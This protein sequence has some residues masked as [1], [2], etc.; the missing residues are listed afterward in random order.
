M[1]TVFVLDESN[2]SGVDRSNCP[3]HAGGVYDSPFG[4]GMPST[5]PAIVPLVVSV[6]NSTGVRVS[7]R[8]LSNSMPN[9][10]NRA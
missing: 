5:A 2:C 7:F 6:F 4:L 9:V 3:G 8:L 1:F 10:C